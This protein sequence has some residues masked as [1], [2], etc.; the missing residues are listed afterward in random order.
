[1]RETS[2]SLVLGLVLAA[3][4]AIA[5]NAAKPLPLDNASLPGVNRYDRCLSL[6]KTNAREA[7]AA[8]EAWHVQGGG[9]AALHCTALALVSLHRYSEAGMK[10]D[11]AALDKNAGGIDMQAALFDQAGNAWLLAGQPQ[12]AEASLTSGL[13]LAPVNG[14]LL[15][16]R[17][18]ARAARKEWSAAEADLNALL[19]ADSNRADALVLRASARHAEGRKADALADIA[20]ALDVY[21]DYPEA[22]V[23]RGAMKYEAGDTI[24]ARA[25]WEQVV[26]DA[27][28]ND[29]GAAAREHLADMDATAAV[30]PPSQ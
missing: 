29:A 13:A 12:R 2:L 6:V 19:D 3:Q 25:D 14:D 30:K 18:R 28:D 11:Q 15:F 8:A 1:M 22:L 20:R 24:G 4:P 26:H 21:P 9:A 7:N 17:A 10:L 16:D 5:A 23:E 27:P